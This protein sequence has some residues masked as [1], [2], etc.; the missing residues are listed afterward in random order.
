MLPWPTL[1]WKDTVLNPK[2]GINFF[3][4]IH[5]YAE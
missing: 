3:Y 5:N 4:F 2:P 1:F